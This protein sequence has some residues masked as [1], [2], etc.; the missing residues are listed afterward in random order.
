MLWTGG[1][2]TQ[3]VAE[4]DSALA[5]DVVFTDNNGDG[6]WQP[7][8]AVWEN[9]AL[10]GVT[11]S[12]TGIRIHDT[13]G[14]GAWSPGEAVWQNAPALDGEAGVGGVLHYT[15]ANGN[16]RWDPGEPV[17]R[18][19]SAA[20]GTVSLTW[21]DNGCLTGDGSREYSWSSDNRLGAIKTGSA[22]VE[23][24]YDGNGRRLAK[25]VTRHD[26]PGSPVATFYVWDG[27][28]VVEEVESVLDPATG[29]WSESL[30]A[31]YLPGLGL[32][33][34]TV[35]FIDD[36]EIH[37]HQDHLGNVLMV[38]DEDGD[39]LERYRYDLNGNV[40]V[41]DEDGEE[42]SPTSE[43]T[44]L[45]SS[46]SPYLFTGRRLD[47]ETGLYYFRNRYYSPL[48]GKFISP[49]TRPPRLRRRH[50]RLCLRQREYS[51]PRRSDGDG[52]RMA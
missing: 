6:R 33:N 14:D 39:V 2:D 17:W 48:L 9:A 50:E 10:A 51:Q 3:Q 42:I 26:A 23:Y 31:E 43:I 15:D 7:G 5:S 45:T 52:W 30:T 32:D 34:H 25:T 36:E 20:P 4:G 27:W 22:V 18:E 44:N 13:D 37:F 46:I 28:T 16:G 35:A 8:E 11:L 1:D 21:N 49:I 19:L 41:L 38:T 47:P 29:F 24:L 12:Q 40:T